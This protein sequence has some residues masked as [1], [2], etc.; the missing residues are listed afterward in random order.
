[1]SWPGLRAAVAP[2]FRPDFPQARMGI[3]SSRAAPVEPRQ[4]KLKEILGE[5]SLTQSQTN[6]YVRVSPCH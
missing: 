5:G 4:A 2:M 6:F 3:G 1:M